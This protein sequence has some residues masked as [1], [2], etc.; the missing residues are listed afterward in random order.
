MAK[1]NPKDPQFGIPVA[2]RMRE[3]LALRFNK[4]ANTAH[5][6]LSR[7]LAE[8]IE[9]AILNEQQLKKLQTEL[10]KEKELAAANES[11]F[12]ELQAEFTKGRE[13]TRKTVGRFIL[14]IT[15]GNKKE[16]AQLIQTYN[17]IFKDERKYN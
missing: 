10:L 7:Y 16:A 9:R 2:T 4:E 8:F 14:E 5:K 3:E 1:L 17:T 15:E 12:K 11:K 13:N 6:T